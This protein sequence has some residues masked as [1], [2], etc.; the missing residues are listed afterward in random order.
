MTLIILITKLVLGRHYIPRGWRLPSQSQ[1]ITAQVREA[2]NY[3]AWWQKNIGVNNLAKVTVQCSGNE[4]G[5]T[6]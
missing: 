6:L 2:P 1:D 4:R 3:T 5:V